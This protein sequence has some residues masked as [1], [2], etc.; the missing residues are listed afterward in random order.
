MSG[1]AAVLALIGLLSGK[2]KSVVKD[3]G[4]WF[5]SAPF[6]L[7]ILSLPYTEN[8][9]EWAPE[10]IRKLSFPLIALGISAQRDRINDL[11]FE[12]IAKVFL[13]ATIPVALFT[14]G[15]YFSNIAYYNQKI[16]ESQG[17][18]VFGGTSHITFS[19]LCSLAI[20]V[21]IYFLSKSRSQGNRKNGIIYLAIFLILFVVFHIVASR[22]GWVALYTGF[23]A[24]IIYEVK[25]R[26][27]LKW[28]LLAL[29]VL[30][31]IPLIA[32]FT[33]PSFHNKILNTL[34]DANR[35]FTGQYIGYYSVSMRFEAWRACFRIFWEHPLLGVG[36]A[37]LANAMTQ[38]YDIMGT[39]GL[40]R[41]SE[42][43]NQ[44]LE[45]AACNG[46]PGIV[47]FLAL[48]YIPV[49]YGFKNELYGFFWTGLLM[50]LMFESFFEIQAGIA[51]TSL[52]YMLF[53]HWNR[54]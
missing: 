49:K 15:N 7:M 23:L 22:T 5:V 42:A 52:F 37:D 34:E 44:L 48:F 32:W 53:F 8:M 2:L 46:I 24:W 26:G 14:A 41:V 36:S 30:S 21:S 51:F 47:C 27:K 16:L 28:G 10:T 45:A 4:F 17:L 20:G 12:T 13:G 18:P 3:P 54:N 35:Y 9:E 11:F 6:F 43:H 29:V 50:S 39:H 40:A 19:I 33:I 25:R 1:G 31:C 38:Q